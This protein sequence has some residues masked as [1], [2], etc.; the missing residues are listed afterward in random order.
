MGLFWRRELWE[1]RR[2]R[3]NYDVCRYGLRDNVYAIYLLTAVD[4]RLPQMLCNLGCLRYSPRLNHHIRQ[5]RPIA[6]GDTW[7]IE[8]RGKAQLLVSL[9][10]NYFL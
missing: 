3:P 4:Y 9:S 10:Y 1:I 6:S 7:E 2:Y 5:L 8:L